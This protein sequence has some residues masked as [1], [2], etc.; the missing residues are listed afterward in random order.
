MFK[1]HCSFSFGFRTPY[2]WLG[3][4]RLEKDNLLTV[5]SKETLF[6]N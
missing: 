1:N 6:D 3:G 5:L 2:T 4:V